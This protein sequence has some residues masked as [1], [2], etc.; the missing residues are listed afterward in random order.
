M[1]RRL[2]VTALAVDLLCGLGGLVLAPSMLG[3]E[4]APEAAQPQ[5]VEVGGVCVEQDEEADGSA[6]GWAVDPAL[7]AQG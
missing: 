2:I 7:C 6:G 1:R 5:Y 4:A 3:G